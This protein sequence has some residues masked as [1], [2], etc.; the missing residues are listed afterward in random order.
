LTGST[1]PD[2][3]TSI[4]SGFDVTRVAF[5]NRLKRHP[6]FKVYFEIKG[7][8]SSQALDFLFSRDKYANRDTENKPPSILLDLDLP[9]ESGLD[10]LKVVRA[11]PDTFII[12]GNSIDYFHGRSR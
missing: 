6:F 7:N 12:P 5:Q 10:V 3:S 1:W 2:R 11:N 8:L 9:L 4:G